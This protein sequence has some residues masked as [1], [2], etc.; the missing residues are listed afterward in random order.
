MGSQ[1]EYL[2][3]FVV[4]LTEK[5]VVPLTDPMQIAVYNELC[6][7][8]KRPSDISAAL[9]IPS[10]SLHFVLDKMTDSGVIIKAK[11]DPDKKSVYYSNLA[12]KIAGSFTPDAGAAEES[13]RTFKD[14]SSHY[15]GMSSVAN[16]LDQYSAE[17]GLGLDQVRRRYARDLADSMKIDVGKGNLEDVIPG[18]KERFA[19]MTGF[20]FSVFALNPLTL[21]FEGEAVMS[22][23]MDMFTEFVGRAVENAT[24]RFYAVTSVEDYCSGDSAR[25]K[26]VYERAEKPSEPYINLSLR[27]SGD[28]GRFL[29]VELDGSVGLITSPVQIDIVDA[30]YERPLCVTDIVNKV[31]APRST[32]TSNILRMVEDGIISV[33]YSESGAAYYGLSCSIIMKKSRGISQDP[34]DI[35]SILSSTRSKEGAFMEGY[36]LYLLSYLK[37]LGFD[38]DYMMVVL[39]AKYMRVAGND[40]PR[41]MSPAMT[42]VKG[43]AHQGLE[44]ASNGIFVRVSDD[45]PADRKVSFKEIFP[46]LSMTPLEGISVEGLAEAAPAKKKR[47]SSVKTALQNRSAKEGGRPIRTVRY[48]TGFALVAML[49][50]IVVFGMSG[51]DQTSYADQCSISL[52]D[53]C[54]GVAFYDDDGNMMQMPFTVTT[55]STVTF[56]VTMDESFGA[57]DIGMVSQGVA[58]PLSSCLTTNDDG[59]FT[60]TVSDD[61]TFLPIMKVDIET[62]GPLSY[63]VY[64]FGSKVSDSYAYG[65]EGYIP[66]ED[67]VEEAG[68]LWVTYGTVFD[69]TAAP[70]SYISTSESGD[71]QFLFQRVVCDAD[72]V[73]GI[74]SAQMPRD[75]VEIHLEGSF[76]ADGWFVDDVLIVQE[77]STVSLK[78][79]STNG[80]V[81]ISLVEMDGTSEDLMLSDMDRTV[82]FQVGDEDV[83]IQYKH[84]GIY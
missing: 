80:R 58:Y 19:R 6:S 48:I 7:G 44:M 63:G 42:F 35:R 31:E 68:G 50:A 57:D 43:M 51:S 30:V 16:M 69:V 84:L 20:R 4:L 18:I 64:S 36:L 71:D 14:P 67:Y 21:V 70:G 56:K 82:T 45:S 33:F 15:S 73:T 40:G 17:I 77:D 59:S 79:V 26:V 83:V 62:D 72:E 11:P 29:M 74:S 41:E 28:T 27:H 54:D 65:F 46:A 49:A 8:S 66:L 37:D 25:Y 52:A 60:V 10:S 13:E 12:L 61:I 39:G 24:G 32:V 22:S 78:F 55:E 23:K 53:G 1:D 47:T 76:E 9:G 75:T 5:G 81:A 34:S 2:R 3:N 38:T